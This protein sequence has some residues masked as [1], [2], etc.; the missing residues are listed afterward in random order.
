MQINIQKMNC[1]IIEPAQL[2]VVQR[3]KLG[4]KLRQKRD[5]KPLPGI[6]MHQAAGTQNQQLE[7]NRRQRQQYRPERS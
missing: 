3:S 1:L 4:G 6:M 5:R 2:S 7:S